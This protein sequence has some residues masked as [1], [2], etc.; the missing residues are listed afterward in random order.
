MTPHVMKRDGCKVPFKSERIKEAILRAAKAAE[1]DDAD[2]CATVAAVVSEQ[3]QGRNQVDINEIQEQV[4]NAYFV[5]QECWKR[6]DPDY[7]KDYMSQKCYDDFVMKLG[8][9]Q[10]RNEVP[11]QKNERLLSAVPVHTFDD[12]GKD[13]DYIWYLIHGKMIDYVVDEKTG[14]MIRGSRKNEAFY[15]YWKF[16]HLNGHWVLDEIRQKDEMDIDEFANS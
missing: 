13:Q 9:M 15:E 8:W 12:L 10:V 4:K 6:Q 3:M 5:I 7:A 1:V 14:R 11:V 2:Y 16:I